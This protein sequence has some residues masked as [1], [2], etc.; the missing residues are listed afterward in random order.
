[1]GN[2]VPSIVLQKYIFWFWLWN[3]F[4]K[5]D[6]V[7]VLL[8]LTRTASSNPPN[9]GLNFRFLKYKFQKNCLNSPNFQN[10]RT[11]EK[12]KRKKKLGLDLL[13]QSVNH[14]H[15]VFQSNHVSYFPSDQCHLLNC[16]FS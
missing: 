7:Q 11:V 15:E 6:P 16:A 8:Y 12:K 5:L 14:F 1:M 10:H 13:L 3:Q 9:H 2:P 4:Q